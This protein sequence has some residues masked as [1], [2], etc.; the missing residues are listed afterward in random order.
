MAVLVWCWLPVTCDTAP[1]AALLPP[2]PT[3]V[4]HQG[5]GNLQ[6]PPAA[7]CPLPTQATSA[8]PFGTRPP[9]RLL[10]SRDFSLPHPH[11]NVTATACIRNSPLRRNTA[12][13]A[14]DE[15]DVR[16]PA[17][18]RTPPPRLPLFL[19]ADT[20]IPRPTSSSSKVHL[21]TALLP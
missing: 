11:H 5:T 21:T 6:R 15:Y 20:D 17:S 3:T 8:A 19:K 16:P 18:R 2:P 4:Y 1:A 7:R 14:N 10:Y 12:T 13:M 9:T